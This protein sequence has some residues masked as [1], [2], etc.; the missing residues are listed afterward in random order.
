MDQ[1]NL[2]LSTELCGL[3]G[4]TDTSKVNLLF[5]I[6]LMLFILSFMLIWGTA[7]A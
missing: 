2:C 4:W 5:L 6:I 7:T 3:W 1:G